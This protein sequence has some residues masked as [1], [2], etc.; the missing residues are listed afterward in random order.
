MTISRQW[1][2]SLVRKKYLSRRSTLLN[3]SVAQSRAIS[4]EIEMLTR[5]QFGLSAAASVLAAAVPVVPA[6]ASTDFVASPQSVV[7]IIVPF[8]KNGPTDQI[9]HFI[10]PHL[11]KALQRRVAV[12]HITG[13]WG[14]TAAKLSSIAPPDGSTLIM[15]QMATHAALPVLTQRYDAVN[16]FT[17]VGLVTTSPMV[18]LVRKDLPFN[19][20]NT[21]QAYINANPNRLSLSHGGIGTASA[22]AAVKFKTA[23]GSDALRE[24]VYTGTASAL[25]DVIQGRSDIL[26]DQLVSALPA[27]KAGQVKA[28]A[29][30]AVMRNPALPGVLTATQQGVNLQA[31]NWNAL[32]A[33]KGMSSATQATLAS[34]LSSVFENPTIASDMR[35]RGMQVPFME[36]RTPESLARLQKRSMDEVSKL[37]RTQESAA[38]A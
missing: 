25:D 27:I 18:V 13:D 9:A 31:E 7:R 29:V 38:V 16:D 20:L 8:A 21:L 6:F 4:G 19:T 30:T 3:L 22:V 2:K 32:F 15:G 24:K 17:P 35:A 10:A 1:R 14:M 12:E 5:R 34:A 11:E 37:L 36:Q 23:M 28:I 26:C 33:P